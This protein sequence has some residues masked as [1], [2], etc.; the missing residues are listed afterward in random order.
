MSQ[1]TIVLLVTL[2]M[3]IMFIWHK[4]PFGVTTMLCCLI[5]A[6]AG[7]V[8]LNKAFTGFGNKTVVLIAPTLALSAALTKTELVLSLIHI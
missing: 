1:L 5:L 8:E 7:V 6:A 4:V 2:F 3:M